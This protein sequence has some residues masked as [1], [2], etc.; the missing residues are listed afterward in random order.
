MNHL[1]RRDFVGA[2]GTSALAGTITADAAPA[3]HAPKRALMKVGEITDAA[4]CNNYPFLARFG[5][6]HTC[7]WY[8]T[9]MV[10]PKAPTVEQLSRLRDEAARHGIEI[11]RT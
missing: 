1:N 6:K 4:V 10:D 9:D 8:D 3:S 11:V 7:G 2:V 5:V